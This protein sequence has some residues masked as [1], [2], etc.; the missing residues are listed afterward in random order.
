VVSTDGA[1][2]DGI[3][4]ER[5][6]ARGLAHHGA[7]VLERTVGDL[8]TSEVTTCVANDTV[9]QLMATMTDLRIRHVPVV[10]SGRLAGIVS[11]GDVVKWRL[12]ELEQENHTLH[13]YIVLGR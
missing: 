6:I 7:A 1:T 12:G 11:I 3:L 5:D 8:M 10:E 4:S 2:I 9:D 13:E